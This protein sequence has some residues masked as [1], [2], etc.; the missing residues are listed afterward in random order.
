MKVSTPNLCTAPFSA[1][2]FI[3]NQLNL[4]QTNPVQHFSIA[5][6]YSARYRTAMNTTPWWK[7]PTRSQWAS[8]L[9]AWVG[10]V[11]DAFDFTIYS[12][13]PAHGQGVRRVASAV[14]GSIT[15]TL[16]VAARRRHRAGW[17]PI[18]GAASCR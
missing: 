4:R 18:A 13:S 17:R 6:Q 14:G 12:W 7:Q 9:A 5:L 8:F 16:L 11:L 3:D 1:T 15:L 10:W 2:W